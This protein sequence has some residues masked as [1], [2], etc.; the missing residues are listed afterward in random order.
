M[1]KALALIASCVITMGSFVG[2]GTSQ[3]DLDSSAKNICNAFNS[4]LQDAEDKGYDTG[5][6]GYISSDGSHTFLENNAEAYDF[7]ISDAQGFCEDMK[8]LSYVVYFEGYSATKAYV[9]DKMDSDKIGTYPADL[10]TDGKKLS[11]FK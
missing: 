8:D 6:A 3:E 9:A 10:N 1:K 7:I 2:C 4:A 11:D 5:Q